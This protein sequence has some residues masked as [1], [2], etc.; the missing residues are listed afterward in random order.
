MCTTISMERRNFG[1]APVNSFEVTRLSRAI[2]LVLGLCCAYVIVRRRFQFCVKKLPAF[3]ALLVR[4]LPPVAY[5]IPLY[6]MFSRMGVLG[7]KLPVILAC[8]FIDTP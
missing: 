4:M 5:T 8:I 3:W 7:T 2:S 6:I 1:A